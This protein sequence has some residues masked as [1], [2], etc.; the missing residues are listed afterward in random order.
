[1][2][3]SK[4]V[5]LGDLDHGYFFFAPDPGASH[6]VRYRAEFDDGREPIAEMFPDKF[7]QW[8]RLLYHR[9]FML[10]EHLHA[11]FVPPQPPPGLDPLALPDWRSSRGLYEARWEGFR[12]HLMRVHGADRVTL[13]RVE[14]RPPWAD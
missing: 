11:S 6:L 14:H 8:P 12:R 1:M 9:H 2:S 7:K 10:S 3:V 4:T 13:T 5:R